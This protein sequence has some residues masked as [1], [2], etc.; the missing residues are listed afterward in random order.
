MG[1]FMNRALV[2]R[3]GSTI[4]IHFQGRTFTIDTKAAK[5]ARAG[6]HAHVSDGVIRS[7]MPGKVLK[8]HFK[9]GDLVKQGE[10]IC[11]LEAMKMEYALKAPFDGKIKSMVKKA[12]DQVILDEK[13]A[14][15]EK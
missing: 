8:T 3:V 11:V 2:K 6:T 15:I 1:G 12:G 9:S 7:P 4:W 10:T 13:I 5:S 14:E